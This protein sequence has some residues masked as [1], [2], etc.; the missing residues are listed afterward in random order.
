M[1]SNRVGFVL[2]IGMGIVGE[3]SYSA[4]YW[5]L[6]TWQVCLMFR[7]LR[8]IRQRMTHLPSAQ[9]RS[10]IFAIS[11]TFFLFF[12]KQRHIKPIKTTFGGIDML[13]FFHGKIFAFF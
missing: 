4:K 3:R 8:L 2:T 1:D 9:G 13:F 12:R 6:N 7:P 11:Q 5:Q 10:R